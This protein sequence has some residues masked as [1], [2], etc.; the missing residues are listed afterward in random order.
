MLSRTLFRRSSTQ[1]RHVAVLA[2]ALAL[3][4][5]P[6]RAQQRALTRWEE[7]SRALLRELVEINT[8]HSVGNTVTAAE[9][10]AKH[11]R[12]AGWP[13]EDVVVVENAP[14]KGNL[15]VRYRG[16]NRT[17]KPVLLL[18]H[19]DV[20]E[21]DPKDWTLPPFQ[22]IEKDGTFYGR[23]VADDK[24]ESAIHLTI[25]L[26]MKAEG[27]VPDRD[28]IVALTADEEGGTSNGVDWML[29]NRPE[30]LQAEFAFNEGGGGRVED[31][32]KIS[33]D[34]QASE[35]KVAN[36]TVEA[37]N[38]GGHSSV[39]RPDNAITQLAAALVKLGAY[40]QPVKLNE[41]TRAYFKRQ[42]EI[43]GGEMG[44]A[45]RA[46]IA[47][48]RDAAAAATMAKDPANNSRM[49]TTCVATMLTGGHASTA[50]PQRAT[51]T[52]NCRILPDES[53]EEVQKRLIATIADTG[54]KVTV[55]RGARESPP[56]PLTAELLR[57]IE[58]TTKEVWPG[59]PVVPTMSTGATDGL[60]LRRAGI[61][62][63][64]VSGLFYDTPNAHGMNEHVSAQAFY[65]GLEFMYRLV[66]K[67]AGPEKPRM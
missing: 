16:S 13:A 26:R 65:D 64:G 32:K 10:M 38:P 12:A 4:V 60:Y 1:A 50:L 24:D 30:L 17:R 6:L 23:G 14:R 29:T 55:A 2:A 3:T 22:F 67:V 48:E 33:N 8:T 34:V 63:Y 39:P 43:A 52:V 25:L 15:V 18:S 27:I 5:T 9:A 47:N 37:T 42:A 45:M 54:V 7:Q 56:S 35:K 11:M 58:E 21:A 40:H 62:V 49:R 53:T 28:I 36:F 20:V 57:T 66:K 46:L 61:P 31:G 19:I 44:A 59:M 51:A 41:V